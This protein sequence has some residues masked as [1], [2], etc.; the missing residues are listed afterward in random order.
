[1]VSLHIHFDWTQ[2]S[3]QRF[4]NPASHRLHDGLGL[5]GSA[6]LF[7]HNVCF[8]FGFGLE[9]ID[10][11]ESLH[12]GMTLILSS[13]EIVF[14]AL[15]NSHSVGIKWSWKFNK[16][17]FFSKIFFAGCIQNLHHFEISTANYIFGKKTFTLFTISYISWQSQAKTS[18][19][20]LLIVASRGL[21]VYRPNMCSPQTISFAFNWTFQTSYLE[22]IYKANEKTL[23]RQ[24]IIEEFSSYIYRITGALLLLYV[25]CGVVFYTAPIVI[26]I[27][28]QTKEPWLPNFIPGIDFNTRDGFIVTSIFHCLVIYMATV[29]FGFID[30]LFINLVL[31]MLPIAK[32][33][34]NELLCL[35]EDM[36]AKK[37]NAAKIQVRLFNFF[38]QNKEMQK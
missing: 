15:L 14:Q 7:L 11:P 23:S 16:I 33:Q 27:I 13:F 36:R 10:L 35:N 32:L 12:T 1:M 24:D 5:F 38:V 25:L 30:S 22:K 8:W 3:W 28:F 4:P 26:Y 18:K 34:C 17:L 2:C 6:E 37:P 9:R 29:G 19:W 20:N 31:N 21:P